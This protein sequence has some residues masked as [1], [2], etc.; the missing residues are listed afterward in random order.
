MRLRRKPLIADG[1]EL[2]SLSNDEIEAIADHIVNDMESEYSIDELISIMK[3]H[4]WMIITNNF[5]EFY[6]EEYIQVF[7]DFVVNDS[8]I[9]L[10]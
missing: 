8:N 4:D 10:A 2:A 9:L 6:S 3:K 1:Y 7:Y 5:I